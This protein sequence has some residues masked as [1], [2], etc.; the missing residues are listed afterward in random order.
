MGWEEADLSL[1]V[2]NR[3]IFASGPTFHSAVAKA[4]QVGSAVFSWLRRFGLSADADKTEVMFF[5]L[6]H[7]PMA[8]YGARPTHVTFLN[9]PDPIW[10]KIA[11][12]LRYLGVFFMPRLSWTLHV[13]TMA[14]QVRSTVKALGILGNSA[15][16]FSLIRWRK[17]FQA[18]L[19]PV[20]TYGAQVWFTDWHQSGLLKILQT[21]QN[22][23]CQKLVGVFKTT[24]VN[25]IHTLLRIPPI[26]YRLHHLLRSAGS[27]IS[28]LPPPHALRNTDM[29]RQVTGVPRHT[30]VLPIIPPHYIPKTKHPY[31][32]LPHPGAPPW[33]HPHFLLHKKPLLKKDPHTAARIALRSNNPFTIKLFISTKPSSRPDNF[34]GLFGIFIDNSLH[35]SDFSS[36][37]TAS[38][39]LLLA[40]LHGL[41]R[42]P[43]GWEVL[44]F[45][46]DASLPSLFS[47]PITHTLLTPMTNA[48]EDYLATSHP[49]TITGFW[50]S[51]HWTWPGRTNWIPRLQDQE[52]F[53]NLNDLIPIASSKERVFIEWQHDWTPIPRTD[54]HR[55]YPILADPPGVELHPC[56]QGVLSTGSCRIQC[57]VFQLA[58]EHCF[59]ANYSIKFRPSAGD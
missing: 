51:P 9:G 22:E 27:R 34:L 30:D 35:I 45:F 42:S 56:T 38:G 24:P 15:R 6:P 13:T 4:A 14:I 20:L 16:G 41:R 5:T 8:L 1:Y 39:A 55:H 50:A 53:A 31:L 44:I 23:A 54:H 57:A 17:L 58:T 11:N 37:P 18:L 12:S 47:P 36:Y 32:P 10:V 29:S 52:Y 26:D 19:M 46:Q 40:L 21:A 49:L 33:S 48:L 28:L 3:A 2:N 59:A 43:P 25:F 7:T